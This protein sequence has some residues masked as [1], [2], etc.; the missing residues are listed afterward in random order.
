MR[1][2]SGVDLH[3][4]VE[5]AVIV[6]KEV[7]DLDEGDEKAA[8]DAVDCKS[9]SHFFFIFFLVFPPSRSFLLFPRPL[10]YNKKKKKRKGMTSDLNWDIHAYPKP[11]FSSPPFPPPFFS[12][13][14]LST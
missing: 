1:R 14:C 4:E 6:G 3:F 9:L 11:P 13:P 12:H 8:M 7:R 2:P 10:F 5:L